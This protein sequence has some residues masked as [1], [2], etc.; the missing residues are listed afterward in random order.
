MPPK[1]NNLSRSKKASGKKRKATKASTKKT[2]IWSTFHKLK[3]RQRCSN[4]TLK[5]NFST[6]PSKS[7]RKRKTQL[8][9][10]NTSKSKPLLNNR[11]P[12]RWSKKLNMLRKWK[13]KMAM[14][15]RWKVSKM[16]ERWKTEEL[17]RLESRKLSL[18]KWKAK[19]KAT[20]TIKSNSTR[21]SKS[22]D[23]KKKQ[24]LRKMNKMVEIWKDRVKQNSTLSLRSRKPS[25]R[26]K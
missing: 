13:E 24:R 7:S 20:R 26:S 21:S 11:L 9:R 15:E 22:P 1:A 8:K 3:T 25:S 17:S 10:N 19:E 18:K 23:M 2:K 16:R 5:L 6:S 12:S 14:L 4:N